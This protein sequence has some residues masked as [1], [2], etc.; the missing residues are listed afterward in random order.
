MKKIISIILT[1][2]LAIAMFTVTASAASAPQPKVS[3]KN[4]DGYT[5][6]TIT[7]KKGTTV[8]YT[9]DGKKP[10]KS[11]KK[12]SG[13]LTFKKS[14]V[15]RIRVYKSGCTTKYYRYNV[16][17]TNK[18]L[19]E[20]AN[21]LNNY[22]GKSLKTGTDIDAK[23]DKILKKIIKKDMTNYEKLEAIYDWMAKN[24]KYKQVLVPIYID[25]YLDG[26]EDAGDYIIVE[27][28]RFALENGY[29]VCDNF[30]GLFVVMCRAVGI[31]AYMAN[32]QCKSS[33]GGY[34]GH[35]W[36]VVVIND[37]IAAQFDPMLDGKNGTGRR[38][39]ERDMD[40][41][42]YKSRTVYYFGDF[43]KS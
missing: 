25:P 38:Y 6:V 27:N 23:V 14:A 34:T 31:P 9:T 40:T 20:F 2:S 12:Y 16:D 22:R 21:A 43:K 11:S 26:F 3:F 19:S 10:T 18:N 32:G 29:G 41:D 30:M 15:L 5:V 7:P 42:L 17:V 35:A 13:K 1:L 28:A 36:P 37:D 39:F 24:I 4:Y 8:R 33:G